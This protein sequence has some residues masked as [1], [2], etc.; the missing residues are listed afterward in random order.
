MSWR[1]A[2]ERDLETA[3]AGCDRGVNQVGLEKWVVDEGDC[4]GSDVCS[5]VMFVTGL[6]KAVVVGV[7]GIGDGGTWFLK[8]EDVEGVFNGIVDDC[9]VV[10]GFRDVVCAEAKGVK[11]GREGIGRRCSRGGSCV[12]GHDRREE[13]GER[14]DGRVREKDRE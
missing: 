14:N 7:S 5:V 12:R 9:D 3:V 13:R 8:A 6:C 11:G 4:V 10:I 1:G 2:E